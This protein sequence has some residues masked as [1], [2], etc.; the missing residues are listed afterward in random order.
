MAVGAFVKSGVWPA[1]SSGELIDVCHIN[2]IFEF[3][4]DYNF[5]QVIESAQ[6]PSL[7]LRT[8]RMPEHHMQHTSREYAQP[9]KLL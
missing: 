5:R 4:S 8:L 2:T 6:A 1:E 7:L 9:Q 3:D